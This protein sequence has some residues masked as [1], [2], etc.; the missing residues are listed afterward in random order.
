MEKCETDT[1]RLTHRGNK[2]MDNHF[3]ARLVSVI[4]P[5][6]NRPRELRRALNSVAYQN[7]RPIE[8]VV[9]DDGSTDETPQVAR[10]FPSSD[11]LHLRCIHLSH[12]GNIAALR[13]QGLSSA[14]GE[15][16]QFLD[17]DDFFGRRKID[18]QAQALIKNP[19]L[20]FVWCATVYA[21]RTR[22]RGVS[23][24][25]LGEKKLLPRYI[26]SPLWQTAAPLYRRS[27][28]QQVGPL[29]EELK[30]A[31]D[32]DFGIR[33]LVTEPCCKRVS[34]AF[35]Y[36][37]IDPE[38]Q[39][40]GQLEV[41]AY[42]EEMLKSLQSAEDTLHDSGAIRKPAVRAALASRYLQASWHAAS[43]NKT[44]LF[45]ECLKKARDLSQQKRVQCK[46]NLLQFLALWTGDEK[47]GKI[48][49]AIERRFRQADRLLKRLWLGQTPCPRLNS[50]EFPSS[51]SRLY[52]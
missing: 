46:C 40:I 44:L 28:C 13:N 3:Q 6:F 14:R 34:G 31:E 5:V 10:D 12:I 27:L 29:N 32:W 16:I 15:Y 26:K 47:A 52:S 20:D 17:S 19:I 36:Y 43:R 49:A 8:V 23:M 37:V 2:W 18:L 50:G 45:K 21:G 33:V 22:S 30:F 35:L 42:L 51:V 11:G 1:V 9:I 38:G 7:Y 41:G 25:W 39:T 48:F 24:S 4:I